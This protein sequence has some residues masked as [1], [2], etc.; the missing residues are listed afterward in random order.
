MAA[1]AKKGDWRLTED[2]RVYRFGRKRYPNRDLYEGE[3][4]DGVR[5]GNGTLSYYNGN[6]Y[7][8]E[9]SNQLF[10]GFGVFT[11]APFL[12][13]GQWVRG[14]RYEGNW[15]KGRRS[16]EGIYFSGYGESYEGHFKKDLYEGYGVL[17]KKNGDRLSGDWEKGKMA[18]K[19]KVEYINGNK[20]TGEMTMGKFHGDGK[21]IFA[22]GLGWYEGEYRHGKQHGRGSRLF[23]N[24]SRYEGDFKYGQMHGE[25]M[26]EWLNG[27]QYVGEWANGFPHGRGVY[28][29]AHG[30]RYEGD[31][32]KGVFHGRG[33]LT[34]ADGGYYDGEFAAHTRPGDYLHGVVFPK[35][36]GKRHG[37]GVRVWVSGNRY[38]GGWENGMM[39]G[40]GIYENATTGGK[41]DGEFKLNKKTGHGTET[42]GNKLGIRFQD[43]MGW[44]H[45]GNGYCRYEGRYLDG[46]FHGEGQFIAVD[47]RSYHG[48]WQKGKRHGNGTATLIPES[49]LG[50]AFNMNVGGNGALYRPY[51]YKGE[52]KDNRKHG[53]GTL[54]YLNGLEIEGDFEFGHPHG[55]CVQKYP[56]RKTDKHRVCRQGRW[57][58]GTN[59]EWFDYSQEEEEVASGIANYLL[60]TMVN[61]KEEKELEELGL[62]G[63]N[64]VPE[65]EGGG[66]I[67]ASSIT[68]GQDYQ[69]F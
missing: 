25:G 6:K 52:W 57:Y 63:E 18:G 24:D 31:F 60:N 64:K 49:E 35:P 26:M 45:D 55:N 4:L 29:Y 10:H 32:F 2:G 22:N 36:D 59:V 67:V 33:R 54:T 5:E 40:R 50:D 53:V 41:Y 17:T 58:K 20:Y 1:P 37:M 69:K 44:W 68:D 56:K 11:W 62:W 23:M 61:T 65:F 51:S 42:W 66:S 13:N 28:I 19:A 48:H 30:D 8:G 9:F 21:F 38:E 14:R 43:P 15:A 16:G 7:E 46:Y 3:F 47:N 12:E 39:N 34:Y 27:D